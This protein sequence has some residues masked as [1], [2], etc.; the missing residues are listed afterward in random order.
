MVKKLEQYEEVD[1]PRCLPSLRASAA[2]LTLPS[3]HP[4]HTPTTHPL[5]LSAAATRIRAEVEAAFSQES[6]QSNDKSE[7]Q[8]QQQLSELSSPKHLPEKL[9]ISHGHPVSVRS[10]STVKQEPLSLPSP[11]PVSVPERTVFGPPKTKRIKKNVRSMPEKPLKSTGK[12]SAVKRR[13]GDIDPNAPKKPSNAFF[14]FCQAKR[15]E[16]QEQFKGE[17]TT[18][19]HDLTKA[20]ARLWGETPADDRKVGVTN[21]K[22]STCVVLQYSLSYKLYLNF[23]INHVTCII[24]TYLSHFET[25]NLNEAISFTYNYSGL[26]CHL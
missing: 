17:V 25:E 2:G 21:N 6:D 3:S 10:Q 22:C 19:Q 8:Q 7:A 24:Y 13:K 9:V 16:L 26:F 1:Y 20:L 4:L 18:G 12:G 23:A 15:A 14:W 5:L 11:S